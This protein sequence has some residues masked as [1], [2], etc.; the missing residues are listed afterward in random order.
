M[1]TPTAQTDADLMRKALQELKRL[2]ARVSSLKKASPI[3]VLGMACRFPGGSD[4]PDAFWQLLQRGGDGICPVPEDRWDMDAYYDPA[5]Y[6]VGKMYVNQGGFLL[7]SE[8]LDPAT[9]PVGVSERRTMDPQ[10]GLLLKVSAEAL[11]DAQLDLSDPS[12]R[13][14]GV[15]IGAMGHDHFLQ[16]AAQVDQ[17]ESRTGVGNSNSVLAGRISFFFDFNG[18]SITLDTSCSSSLVAL[19][20]A[21]MSLRSHECEQALV[22]GVNLMLHPV[23]SVALCRAR[24]L[25]ADGRCKTFDAAADGY[26]RGEGCGVVVLK[27]LVNAERDGN[28]VLGVLCG[29]AVNHN[30]HGSGLT[31]PSVEAQQQV[32]RQALAQARMNPED[33]AYVETH[34]TGTRLGDP[35]EVEALSSVYRPAGREG[36]PLWIGSVKTNIGH[37]EG[38]AGMASVLK[39]LLMLNHRRIPANLHFKTPSPQIDWARIPLHVP[40]E[41]IPWALSNMTD[42]PAA[43]ISSFGFNGSNAHLIV[44]AAES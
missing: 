4:S 10:Q 5:P 38:A 23:M 3:A 29:S 33:L 17:M 37:L 7:G 32:L 9:F 42:A 12:L 20:Q 16:V 34:G 14:T 36:L 11:A 6:S 15:F 31:V 40:V 30:G 28:R 2:R 25:A 18:P 39:V 26:G 41:N 8:P 27:R 1:T 21:C 44:R 24:M 35:L 22:G 19:H 43:G 13:S